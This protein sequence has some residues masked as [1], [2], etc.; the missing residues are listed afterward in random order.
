MRKRRRERRNARCLEMANLNGREPEQTLGDHGGQT[1]GPPCSHG[2]SKSR[3]QLSNRKTTIILFCFSLVR[4]WVSDITKGPGSVLLLVHGWVFKKAVW[5]VC[6]SPKTFGAYLP[7]SGQA[8]FC[9][10]S[11]IRIAG[12]ALPPSPAF[13]CSRSVQSISLELFAYHP[14]P[15]GT[16]GPLGAEPGPS[17]SLLYWGAVFL[18]VSPW[19]FVLLLSA[20]AILP[21]SRH[22]YHL[23]KRLS[24]FAGHQNHLE[25]VL[26]QLWRPIPINSRLLGLGASRFLPYPLTTLTP[27]FLP[28]PPHTFEAKKC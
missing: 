24:H 13:S 17:F 11:V 21:T 9:V 4:C 6:G 28:T 2:V 8:V 25:L 19:P 15:C 16:R 10:A 26:T 20:W 18:V 7:S 12:R 27:P 3:T 22:Q 1:A 14:A 5:V 23:L